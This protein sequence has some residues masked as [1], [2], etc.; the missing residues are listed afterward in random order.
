MFDLICGPG[1]V[2]FTD[3]QASHAMM[4]AEVM[5]QIS[6]SMGYFYSLCCGDSVNHRT[7]FLREQGGAVFGKK[8]IMQPW[9][10]GRKEK[11]SKGSLRIRRTLVVFSV[12]CTLQVVW[13][14][15]F[16]HLRRSWNPR[17]E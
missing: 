5:R 13:D 8:P 15:G 6:S 12:K 10:E 17:Y 14:Y 4:W 9:L 11:V 1:G 2:A 16:K 3:T 7:N